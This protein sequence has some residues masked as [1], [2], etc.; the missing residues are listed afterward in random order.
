MPISFHTELIGCYD[1][2]H[3]RSLFIISAVAG[4]CSGGG[5]FSARFWCMNR[6]WVI[7]DIFIRLC[8]LKFLENE[9]HISI[10][11][12]LAIET[13]SYSGRS[14]LTPVKPE[15]KIEKES[16]RHSTRTWT[17]R[18][19]EEGR[20]KYVK[21]TSNSKYWY[22]MEQQHWMVLTLCNSGTLISFGVLF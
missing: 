11:Q 13:H 21:R 22:K 8:Y 7:F 2:I 17:C 1:F 10:I 3:P 12:R 14:R 15:R 18:E 20:K 16:R 4:F 6:A 5:F 9:N 19:G